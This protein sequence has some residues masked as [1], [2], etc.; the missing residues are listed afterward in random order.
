M[1]R[2]GL[3]GGD[4]GNMRWFWCKNLPSFVDSGGCRSRS[5]DAG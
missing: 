5:Y 2:A 3:G 4:G 1:A